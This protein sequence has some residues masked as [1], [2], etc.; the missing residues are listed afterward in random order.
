MGTACGNGTVHRMQP[1]SPQRGV[2]APR[3][4]GYF[5]PYMGGG[6]SPEQR[7]AALIGPFVGDLGGVSPLGGP[8]TLDLSSSRET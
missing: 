8:V 1:S 3:F 4:G 5:T 6:F 7:L 2:E